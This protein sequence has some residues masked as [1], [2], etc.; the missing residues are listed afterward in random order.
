MHMKGFRWNS[1]RI[2]L[3]DCLSQRIQAELQSSISSSDIEGK[4]SGNWNFY[5]FSDAL[6][7]LTAISKTFR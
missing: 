7:Q 3:K 1:R 2:S 6:S 5:A 4:S